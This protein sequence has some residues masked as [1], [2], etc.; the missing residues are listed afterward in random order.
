[1]ADTRRTGV[2]AMSDDPLLETRFFTVGE[3]ARIA[4]VSKMT[5][6]REVHA[7]RLDS[8]R[9]GRSFRIPEESVR[10]WLGGTL[11]ATATA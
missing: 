2:V 3:I 11:T 10:R 7:G 5:V 6:Y 1:V 8:V 9:I 4:R